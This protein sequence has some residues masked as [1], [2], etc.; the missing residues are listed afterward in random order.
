MRFN[1]FVP[2]LPHL[3]LQNVCTHFLLHTCTKCH[4]LV[5]YASFIVLSVP[6]LFY[7]GGCLVVPQQ[8]LGCLEN[9][10]SQYC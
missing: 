1:L 5:S 2:R 3:R 7:L 8:G 4:V 6:W 9:M 10:H